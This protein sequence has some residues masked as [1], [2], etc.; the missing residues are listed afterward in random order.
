[1]KNIKLPSLASVLIVINYF[2]VVNFN[3]TGISLESDCLRKAQNQYNNGVA[4][5]MLL[6]LLIAA[7]YIVVL[8]RNKIQSNF[9]DY[10]FV[11]PVV[12]HFIYFII[13]IIRNYFL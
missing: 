1:M 2:I 4:N 11:S 3:F 6:V 8:N 5:P 12:C 9:L 7:I 13:V 10:L